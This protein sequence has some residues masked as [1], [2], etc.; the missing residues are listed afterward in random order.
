MALELDILQERFD[1]FVSSEVVDWSYR[2]RDWRNSKHVDPRNKPLTSCFLSKTTRLV[3]I[4]RRMMKSVPQRGSVWLAGF[5]ESE[6][7]VK[8][9]TLPRGGTDFV[10]T[11]VS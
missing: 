6:Y 11:V 10:A 7:T 4:V 2:C 1:N 3:T 8:S 5:R 9:H